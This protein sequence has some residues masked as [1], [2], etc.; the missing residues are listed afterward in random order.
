M[1][2]GSDSRALDLVNTELLNTKHHPSN[3]DFRLDLLLSQTTHSPKAFKGL[4]PMCSFLQLKPCKEASSLH[5]TEAT[6]TTK[7]EV[8][9]LN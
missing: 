9:R 1:L 8:P 7:K 4:N 2:S 3:T 6:T 5:Q